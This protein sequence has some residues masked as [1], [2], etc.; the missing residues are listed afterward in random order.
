MI[1][2]TQPVQS[3]IRSGAHVA[4]VAKP[5]LSCSE[6]ETYAVATK[7]LHSFLHALPEKPIIFALEGEMGAG[8]TH[9]AKGIGAALKVKQVVTSP[10]YVLVKE[11]VGSVREDAVTFIHMDCWRAGEITA[12]EV[13]LP[14]YLRKNTVI[15]IEW[16]APLMS[17]LKDLGDSAVVQRLFIE[18]TPEGRSIQFLEL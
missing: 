3:I 18:E 13:G 6:E 14:E 16:A 5:V 10:T 15:V 1:D 11:Y 8:K 17:F 12:E 2:T 4:K 7:L 9:F